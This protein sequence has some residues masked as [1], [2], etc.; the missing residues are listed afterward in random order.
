MKNE[1]LEKIVSHGVIYGI[2]KEE[3]L[4]RL[5]RNIQGGEV[6]RLKRLLKHVNGEK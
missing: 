3:D 5:K 4:K 6:R 1:L 2:P